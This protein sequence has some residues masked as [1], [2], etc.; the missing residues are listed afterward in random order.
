MVGLI[1][2][3][4]VPTPFVFPG[5]ENLDLFPFLVPPFFKLGLLDAQGQMSWNLGTIPPGASGAQ[6]D[7]QLLELDPQTL[8]PLAKSSLATLSVL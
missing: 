1:G 3:P 4:S 5:G 2:D 6:L 7:F 8:A